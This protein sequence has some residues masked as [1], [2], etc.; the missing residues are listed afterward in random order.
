MVHGVADGR[1]KRTLQPTDDVADV[2]FSPD[3]RTMITAGRF[4]KLW[5]ARSFA[6]ERTFKTPEFVIRAALSAD[7]RTLV[8]GTD[9]GLRIWNPR[10]GRQ[11][12]VVPDGEVPAVAISPDSGTVA[13]GGEAGK[14]NLLDAS[15]HGKP[16]TLA[17]FPGAGVL[18][19]AFSPDGARLAAGLSDGTARQ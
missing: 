10:S 16:R 7:G 2:R 4:V 12:R 15:G 6:L 19:A 13:Y 17:R 11:R 3:E 8:G 9:R 5:D 18:S 1:L 14:L